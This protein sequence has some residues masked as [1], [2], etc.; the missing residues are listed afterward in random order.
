MDALVPL[1]TG[2]AAIATPAA[3]TTTPLWVALA[4][5]VGWTLAGIGALA[6]PFSWRLSRMRLRDRLEAECIEEIDQVFVHLRR[7]RIPALRRMSRTILE[8]FRIKLDTQIAGLEEA[9]QQASRRLAAGSRDTGLESKA[10]RVREI[11]RSV[12]SQA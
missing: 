9:I 6:V 8:D 1:A 10:A 7:D 3:I 5:P 12:P 2:T 4:G 11:L